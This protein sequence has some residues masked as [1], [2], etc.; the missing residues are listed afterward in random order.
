[1]P[2][3]GSNLAAFWASAG[4]G[5]RIDPASSVIPARRC[6]PFP[7]PG[8]LFSCPYSCSL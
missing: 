6:L 7:T 1:L 2:N 5:E 3:R 4:A 8:P